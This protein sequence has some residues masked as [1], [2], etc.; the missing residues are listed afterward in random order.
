MDCISDYSGEMLEVVAATKKL[1]VYTQKANEFFKNPIGNLVLPDYQR[2]YVWNEEKVEQL[3]MDWYEHF[4]STEGKFQD[5]APHYYMG[6]VLFYEDND[7]YY[8]VDEQQRIT[9]LLLID[10]IVN[11]SK[12][13][14]NQ[15]KWDLN[16]NSLLSSANI[17]NNYNYLRH[18]ELL[19]KIENLISS[20]FQKLIFTII[21]TDSEDEACYN[22]R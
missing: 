18:S 17:K 19:G 6:T 10:H 2:P 12:F 21:I 22:V 15:D 20:I 14:L 11:N 1:T 7:K 4:F 9:T 16:Y 5:V 8:V 13:Y 3:L